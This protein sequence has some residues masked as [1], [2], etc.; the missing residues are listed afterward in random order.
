MRGSRRQARTVAFQV[1]CEVDT[2]RHDPD[3]VLE[4]LLGKS[5]LSGEGVD[6]VRRTVH[7]VLDHQAEV[8]TYIRRFA[9]AWPVEQLAVVDRSLLRL[10]IYEML[11]D[12]SVPVRVAINEAVELAKKYGS[13]S[14]PR[15][16]N[17]V[18]GAISTFTNQEVGSGNCS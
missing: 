8:D 14:S 3:T 11:L 9:P 5:R 13:E 17:G 6:F 4:H 1:L 18:L 15:F 12:S 7:G 16:V 10:A 2:T